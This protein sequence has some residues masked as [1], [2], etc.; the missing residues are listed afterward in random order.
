MTLY[1]DLEKDVM[2][3]SKENQ[4]SPQVFQIFELLCNLI[5]IKLDRLEKGLT[6]QTDYNPLED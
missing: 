6:T 5:D 2:I 1:S 4:G 3:L